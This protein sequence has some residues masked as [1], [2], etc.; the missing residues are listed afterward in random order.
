MVGSYGTKKIEVTNKKRDNSGRI[1]LL[2]IDI[3]DNLFVLINIY[4]KPDQ[5]KT[6]T[7]L[8]GIIDCVGDIENKYIIF[9][10]D[11][12]V[13]FYSYLKVQ[14]GKTNLKKAF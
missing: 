7:H 3:D 1:L 5:L 12:N 10:S 6:L 13:I 14:E 4:N 9:G 8:G 2:E 11:F